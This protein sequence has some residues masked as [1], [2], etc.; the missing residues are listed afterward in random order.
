MEKVFEAYFYK[1]KSF[2]YSTILIR[3]AGTKI[4]G[5]GGVA[6]GPEDLVKGINYIQGIL[7]KRKGMKLKSI[8]CLD[9]INII[10]S[11]VV[12][13]NV[14]RCLPIGSKVHTK[15]GLINIEDIIIGD[16]VQ[17]THGYKKVK[18][19]F[20]QG[21]QDIY[22]IPTTTGNFRCT[23][24]HKMAKYNE[25]LNNYD[26]VT[27]EELDIPDHLIPEIDR[28]ISEVEY[29]Y[30]RDILEDQAHKYGDPDGDY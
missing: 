25:E 23:K 22:S 11:V 3:S 29:E 30:N 2:S 21:H 5:F 15:N 13:G 10:A 12:A 28:Y 8:D 19:C 17:T 26:W 9:I 20:V 14:R 7:N 24:N 16:E 18:N 6:S 27:A 1:G 4:K